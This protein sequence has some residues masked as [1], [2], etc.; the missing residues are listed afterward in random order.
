MQ[1]SQLPKIPEGSGWRGMQYLSTS[2]PERDWKISGRD[3]CAPIFHLLL[4]S[5]EREVAVYR[6][7]LDL[8][9]IGEG[10]LPAS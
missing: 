4:P 2:C 10:G 9:E 8:R 3:T 5:G 6:S 1:G 7:E